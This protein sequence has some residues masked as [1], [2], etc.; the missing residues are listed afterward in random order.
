M[1]RCDG[2][3]QVE[4]TKP[5]NQRAT[6]KACQHHV[7]AMSQV[8]AICTDTIEQKP[9]STAREPARKRSWRTWF[10]VSFSIRI[11]NDWMIF[12]CLTCRIRKSTRRTIPAV[13]PKRFVYIP[14]VFTLR[15][16]MV[17]D[18]LKIHVPWGL[19]TSTSILW[20]WAKNSN[21]K[22]VQKETS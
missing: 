12:F 13:H 22:F 6:Q 10:Y 21:I 9:K 2:K 11:F 1:P 17:P 3:V 20:P 16:L 5:K 7:W 19:S 18:M 14:T 4:A 8:T 15:Q